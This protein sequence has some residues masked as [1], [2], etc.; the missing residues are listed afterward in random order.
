MQAAKTLFGCYRR[1]DAADPETFSAA[2][3]AVFSRYAPEVVR[4]VTDP[5][6]GLP[7]TSKFLP[8][9]SEVREAC[10]LEAGRIQRRADHLA[11]IDRQIAER[12]AD[13]VRRAAEVRPSLD[14]LK[15][16]H[17]P[18]WGLTEQ[19]Q[20]SDRDRKRRETFERANRLYFERECAAAG[21]D[22][23]AGVSPSLL[24]NLRDKAP[25]RAA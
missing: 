5:R 21:V 22:P 2:T 6:T 10:E 19:K 12:K 16:K 9:I 15:A 8:T 3:A 17:G 13:E 1:D 7:G 14:D 20:D 23:A 24:Q 25:G 11:Q 4:L 18:N